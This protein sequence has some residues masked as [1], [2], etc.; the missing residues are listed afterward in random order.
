MCELVNDKLEEKKD[1]ASILIGMLIGIR[2]L[3]L[4]CLIFWRSRTQFSTKIVVVVVGR[5]QSDIGLI[6]YHQQ[7]WRDFYDSSTLSFYPRNVRVTK[8]WVSR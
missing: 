1:E 4:D 3:N 2:R 5:W 8:I 6:A 7:Q